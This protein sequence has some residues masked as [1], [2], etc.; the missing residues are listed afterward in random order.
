[1][2]R[3]CGPPPRTAGCGSLDF[4][5]LRRLLSHLHNP[6]VYVLLAAAGISALLG[7]GV[8]AGVIAGVV[9]VNM[10]VGYVQ[11]SRAQRALDALGRMVP[12]ETTLVREGIARRVPVDQL[13]PGDVVR[14]AAG[15]RVPADARLTDACTLEVDESALTGESVAGASPPPSLSRRR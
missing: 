13:V 3:H 2:A 15:D 14:V 4:H 1:M 11:E 6:L 5:A 12:T 7:E 8:D 10:L 9:L